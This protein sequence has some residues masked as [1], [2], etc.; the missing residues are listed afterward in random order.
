M[1]KIMMEEWPEGE[2]AESFVLRRFANDK[3]SDLE[4][5]VEIMSELEE[6]DGCAID[7]FKRGRG[8]AFQ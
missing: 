7:W 8:V 2:S 4:K 3:L 1:A 6:A 5:A